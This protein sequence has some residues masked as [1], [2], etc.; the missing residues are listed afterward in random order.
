MGNVK[1]HFDTSESALGASAL[2]AVVGGL[3]AHKFGKTPLAT[4]AGA[5]VGGLGVNAW[6]AH[7]HHKKEQRREEEPH[8]HSSRRSGSADPVDS[9]TRRDLEYYGSRADED[10]ASGLSRRDTGR[11]AY[12]D[13]SAYDSG[14]DRRRRKRSS[15]R[16]RRDDD[17]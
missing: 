8:R 17:Y 7:R 16:R 10:R 12:D 6:E 4:A 2:G 5:A 3:I 15:S 11:A 9:R 13:D 14:E 1:N